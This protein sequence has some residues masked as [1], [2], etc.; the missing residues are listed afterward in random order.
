MSTKVI[1]GQC[2]HQT[3]F[4]CYEESVGKVRGTSAEGTESSGGGDGGLGALPW[5]IFP[6]KILRCHMSQFQLQWIRLYR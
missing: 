5:K 3:F 2:F 1:T 6:Q 4:F